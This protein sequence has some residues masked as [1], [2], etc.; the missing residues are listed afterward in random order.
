MVFWVLE[1]SAVTRLLQDELIFIIDP[2]GE[3][4]SL[5][6]QMGFSRLFDE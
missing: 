3:I 5:Q 6:L 4:S 1:T 2:T